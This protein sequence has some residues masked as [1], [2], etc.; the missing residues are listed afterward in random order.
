M[1]S[2]GYLSKDTIINVVE[3]KSKFTLNLERDP[4]YLHY[5]ALK[6]ERIFKKNGQILVPSTLVFG[7]YVTSAAL[8]LNTLNFQKR[9][10][11]FEEKYHSA[12]PD[13]SS[14]EEVKED[15]EKF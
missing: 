5:R 4:A 3:N 9:S 11:Q 2:Y 7:G 13:F 8:Y 15:F 6:R 12:G 14:I 10:S 1:R